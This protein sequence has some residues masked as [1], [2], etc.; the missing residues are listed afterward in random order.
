MD[1]RKHCPTCA[2]IIDCFKIFV[3][4]PSDLFAGA[5]TNCHYKHHNTVKY[6]ISITP[7]G[8]VSL[9]SNGWA[10]RVSDKFIT[11][12]LGLLNKIMDYSS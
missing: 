5:Q 8:S 7:Q 11:E 9:I 10:G 6:L 3:D 4:T 12:N 2:V 1:F